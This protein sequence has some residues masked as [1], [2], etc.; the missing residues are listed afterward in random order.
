MPLGEYAADWSSPR[1]RAGASR[2][3]RRHCARGT[4]VRSRT[5]QHPPSCDAASYRRRGCGTGDS[6]VTTRDRQDRR[7]R[8]R[9]SHRPRI[10]VGRSPEQQ[11]GVKTPRQQCRRQSRGGAGGTMHKGSNMM[12]EFA[13]GARR[14]G[15]R[16]TAPE[17][18]VGSSGS[19][20][21]ENCTGIAL[22]WEPGCRGSGGSPLSDVFYPSS[23]A[24]LPLLHIQFYLRAIRLLAVFRRSVLALPYNNRFVCDA[25]RA[26]RPRRVLPFRKHSS[27]SDARPVSIGRAF[28]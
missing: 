26:L 11:N 10:P 17:P 21:V 28:F 8:C 18:W 6:P 7:G 9:P 12:H 4:I 23:R 3:S 2:R 13:V 24:N 22:N 20:I 15:E 27:S 19:D 5:H 16:N 14:R 25:I 1:L